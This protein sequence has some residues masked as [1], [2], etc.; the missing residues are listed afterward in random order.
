[1]LE[2]HVVRQLTA[3][4]HH[5]LTAAESSRVQRHLE[6]CEPCR[7]EYE[8][9]RLT[10]DLASQIRLQSAPDSLWEGVVRTLDRSPAA[11]P[12]KSTSPVWWLWPRWAF[13]VASLLLVSV[14]GRVGTTGG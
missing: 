4:C 14:L 12:G 11:L 9:I 6:V 2:K 3:Y 13:A 8:N 5:E 10:V 7:Q 1:M